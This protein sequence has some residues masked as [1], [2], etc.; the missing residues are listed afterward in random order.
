MKMMKYTFL[1]ILLVFC[2]LDI[3]LSKKRKHR[4]T[5]DGI[6]PKQDTYDP[7]YTPKALK[8]Y[9]FLMI[10]PVLD[11]QQLL[12]PCMESVLKDKATELQK[13]GLWS[14][15]ETTTLDEKQLYTSASASL[16]FNSVIV[17]SNIKGEPVQ[18]GSLLNAMLLNT[19]K[20]Q[21]GPF[22]SLVREKMNKRLGT[23]RPEIMKKNQNVITH[24]IQDRR[25]KFVKSTFFKSLNNQHVVRKFRK[26]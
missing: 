12:Q 11:N 10:N 16:F 15:I 24:F 23:I 9:L 3:N 6:A 25:N 2:L 7:N 21:E 20:I 13:K 19:Q 17:S 5:R 26:H 14:S 4:S 18:C 8:E 22:Q 1:L